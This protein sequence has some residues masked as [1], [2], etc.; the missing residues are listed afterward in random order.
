VSRKSE[1][2]TNREDGLNCIVVVI[3]IIII[4]IIIINEDV[5]NSDSRVSNDFM[6]VDND[7]G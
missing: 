4:I 1:S 5:S 6:T 7:G 2:A 3:I